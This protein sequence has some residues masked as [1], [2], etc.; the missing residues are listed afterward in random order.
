MGLQI[1]VGL[2]IAGDDRDND[3]K[4]REVT[5]HS[6]ARKFSVVSH[7]PSNKASIRGIL[8]ISA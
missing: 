5:R 4:W 1:R 7:S 6:Q 8:L 2:L 3:N